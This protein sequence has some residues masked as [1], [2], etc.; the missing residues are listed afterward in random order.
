MSKTLL[1]INVTA[2]W[3]STGKIAEQIGLCAQKHGWESY[4]AYGRYCNPSKSHLIKVGDQL[5][6]YL[7]YAKNRLMDGEGLGSVRATERLLKE[8]DR[9]R[10]DVIHLHN[11][12]DHYLNIPALFRY[13]AKNDIPVVWTQHDLWATTGHCAFSAE[14][15]E[16]WKTGCYDCPAISRFCL[17][18]SKRNYEI[19]KKLF[20]SVKNMTIVPVSE[21]LGT[22]VQQSYLGKYPIK[23][24][25]NGVDIEVFKPIEC[26]VAVKYGLTDKHV[27]LAVSSVW[28]EFKGLNDFISLSG[29]LPDDYR[30]VIVGLTSNQISQLP[31]NMIGIERTDSQMELAQLYSAADIVMSLSSFETFGLTIAEGMACGTPAI[32]YGNAALPELITEDTGRVV[33]SGNLRELFDTVLY[34]INNDFKSL[35][36]LDCRKRAEDVF[37]KNKAWESCISLYN[38]IISKMGGG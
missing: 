7:H 36:S 20:T 33:E 30:I 27:L 9:I 37:D 28:P 2:N 3:G 21:W 29:M 16:K 26:N 18:K 15:C 34:M 14:G 12:H 31:T 11:I 22:Q 23:V 35:H 38:N 17:D 8:I 6:V 4:I 25:K 10:P 13:L 5:D 1:Q 19:K 32:V 24:I